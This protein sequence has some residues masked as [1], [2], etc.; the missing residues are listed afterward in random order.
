MNVGETVLFITKDG[1]F[2]PIQL[3]GTKPT[4]DEVPEHVALNPHVAR[5]ENVKGGVIWPP[6]TAN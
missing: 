3:S 1:H 6:V 4:A 5:V 2:Y